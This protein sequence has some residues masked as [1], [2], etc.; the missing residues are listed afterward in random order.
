VVPISFYNCSHYCHHRLYQRNFYQKKNDYINV[1]I[2]LLLD[3]DCYAHIAQLSAE[4]FLSL[5][6]GEGE[7]EG[8]PQRVL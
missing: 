2:V 8:N 6:I 4:G 3:S 5:V 1:I 7:E